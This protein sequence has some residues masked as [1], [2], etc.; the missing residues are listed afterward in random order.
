MWAHVLC[1]YRNVSLSCW[2][3]CWHVVN[4]KKP[5]HTHNSIVFLQLTSA[6][7]QGAWSTVRLHG[8]CSMTFSL[9]SFW[10]STFEKSDGELFLPTCQGKRSFSMMN[11]PALRTRVLSCRLMH[12]FCWAL[13][14]RSDIISKGSVR[15]ELRETVCYSRSMPVHPV[16]QRPTWNTLPVFSAFDFNL[17]VLL[18]L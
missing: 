4:I 13:P 6:K 17:M 3:M 9:F 10:S 16:T 7:P 8:S 11:P 15:D 14:R 1:N 18:H 2:T 5:H 12:D